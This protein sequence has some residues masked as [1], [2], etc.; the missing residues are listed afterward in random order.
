MGQIRVKRPFFN[1]PS[2]QIIICSPE[3]SVGLLLLVFA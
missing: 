3:G 2:N 1:R